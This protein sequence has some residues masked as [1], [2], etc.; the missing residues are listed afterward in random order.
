MIFCVQTGWIGEERGMDLIVLTLKG[1]GFGLAVAAPVGPM[2]LLCMRRTLASGWQPGLATGAGI[3]TG[4]AAYGCVAALGSGGCAPSAFV[5]SELI[6]AAG[7]TITPLSAQMYARGY[8]VGN[9]PGTPGPTGCRRGPGGTPLL[10][11]HSTPT[12]RPDPRC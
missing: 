5:L 11:N 7:P 3:A 6:G 8:F 9:P 10:R 2:S 4:D 12:T 1:M